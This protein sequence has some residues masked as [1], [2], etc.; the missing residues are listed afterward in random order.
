MWDGTN[1]CEE[2]KDTPPADWIS[3]WDIDPSSTDGATDEKSVL[4]SD[5]PSVEIQLL[6]DRAHRFSR[7]WLGFGGAAGEGR[8]AGGWA[9]VLEPAA[10]R[11]DVLGGC[12]IARR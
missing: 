2:G 11:E 5:A 4:T 8:A 1:A 6:S 9:P 7:W 10:A 3:H 12:G